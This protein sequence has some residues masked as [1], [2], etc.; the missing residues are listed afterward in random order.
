M[1]STELLL[2]CKSQVDPIARE[3][4]VTF[5]M[6]I[7]SVA[8]VGA[9]DH[10]KMMF[11]N[12]LFNAVI[13]SHRN[14]QVHICCYKG[15]DSEPVVTIADKGIG[16]PADKLPH[17]FEEHYRTNEAVQHNKESSGLGLAIVK[18]VAEL[19]GIRINVES[20]FGSGTKFELKFPT[21]KGSQ[22][23]NIKGET[24]WPIS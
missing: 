24:K 13:Y 17:I 1:V 22:G 8:M 16:I 7:H 3:H 6:D 20:R 18:N 12:L 21:S 23:D 10:F 2:W 9:E 14:G 19:Y 11:V 5:K 15:P 4:G